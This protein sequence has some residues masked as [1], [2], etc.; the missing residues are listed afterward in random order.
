MLLDVVPK[1]NTP[2]QDDLREKL[3]QA[4]DAAIRRKVAAQIESNLTGG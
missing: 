3:A 4:L 2:A 1:T